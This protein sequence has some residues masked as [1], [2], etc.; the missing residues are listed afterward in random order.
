MKRGGPGTQALARPLL[1]VPEVVEELCLPDFPVRLILM[2]STQQPY[3]PSRG[4]P[5]HGHKRNSDHP[6]G[7]RT[8]APAL[9]HR[10]CSNEKRANRS[11]R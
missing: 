3:S 9:E 11:D 5:E 7:K 8:L 2:P 4:E 1:W 6:I 10:R